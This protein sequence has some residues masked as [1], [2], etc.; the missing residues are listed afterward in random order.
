MVISKDLDVPGQSKYDPAYDEA[1]VD[2]FQNA[3]REKDWCKRKQI[4]TNA[5]T[6]TVTEDSEFQRVPCDLP[7]FVTFAD[8]IGVDEHSLRNWAHTH[9]SFSVAYARAKEYQKWFLIQNGLSG[10]YQPQSLVF[11]ATNLTDLTN[12]REVKSTSITLD[13]ADIA[14]M[15]VGQLQQIRQLLEA[16][17]DALRSE[18]T[19]PPQLIESTTIDVKAA[20]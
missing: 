2:Y 20:P 17:L 14:R 16:R 10:I 8:Q 13:L 12:T 6:G 15:D 19:K 9:P 11:I 7:A 1:I 4:R 18:P 3:P 5:K